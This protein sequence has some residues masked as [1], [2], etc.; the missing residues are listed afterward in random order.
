MIRTYDLFTA[1]NPGYFQLEILACD[2][3][4]HSSTTNVN[5]YILRDDQR[6][7]IVFNEIPDWVRE[8][9]DNFISL[10]SNITGAI[11]NL[12]DIQFH[13]DKKGRVSY[14][15][16][17]M[18]IHVVNN[19][20]NTILDVERVI[21]MID[22]NKEQLRSL[23]RTYNVVDVQPAIGDKLPDDISTLQLVIIILAVLLCLAGILFVTMN[24]HYRRVHQRKL[25]AIVAGSTGNQ[26]L[27]DI[28]DM[29]NT[30][31]YSF[32]GANPVWMDPFCRN[33]ELAAQ[34]D[35]EDDLPENLSEI[36]DL[37]NSPA[38]TH[39][40]FGR[41]PQARPE[42]DR[43]L[44]AAI[45]EYD[46][47]AKLGQIMREG[48][49]KG[50]LLKVVLDDYLRLK[51]LFAARLATVSTGQGEGDKS[52]VT[53]LIQSDLDDDEDENLDLAGGRGTLRFKHKLPVELKGPEGVHVVHG[54]TGTLLTSDINSLPEDDQ[55]ALARSLEAL[56]ADGGLY[57][58][59]N[60]R[61]ESAK[62]TP[63]HRHKD[64]D[65]L[66]ESPLEITEL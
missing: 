9:Q 47:I 16:T 8:N 64:G 44:R 3:A 57:S 35:H 13:V 59:R 26:G 39:G 50:S 58:E 31:K 12:D 37:W 14:S 53:E 5:I 19:Q 43:Y 40:T 41:E 7:K 45:Q 33:L 62:S 54:S 61:T 52:S 10:L 28:L 66:S 27:M 4:G 17:D 60:A 38:R 20:T 30:N 51:K 56:N 18:L 36:T 22:E 21:Q 15:Q 55:R 34:A 2:L 29:P 65:T 11:V 49:I 32:E 24:W 23:F 6:V 25:K 46:N 48:P 1:Y 42:D 63:M